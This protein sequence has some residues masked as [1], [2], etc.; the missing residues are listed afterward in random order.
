MFSRTIGFFM[1]YIHTYNIVIKNWAW[2]F[3]GSRK[4]VEIPF[5]PFEI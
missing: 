2:G 4:S 3:D 5:L 1:L